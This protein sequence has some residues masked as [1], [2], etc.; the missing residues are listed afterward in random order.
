MSHELLHEKVSMLEIGTECVEIN[1]TRLNLLVPERTPSI[2]EE[3]IKP[4][5][6]QV[7][8]FLLKPSQMQ[9]SRIISQVNGRRRRLAVSGG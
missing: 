4:A 9:I 2:I 8:V 6:I 1:R 3:I 7:A 5:T